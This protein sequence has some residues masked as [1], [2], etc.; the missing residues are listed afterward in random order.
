[1]HRIQVGLVATFLVLLLSCT[2]ELGPGFE[3]S[4]GPD[5]GDTEPESETESDPPEGPEP[6]P[7]PEPEPGPEPKPEPE[8]TPSNSQVCYPG[9]DLA[10]TTCFDLVEIGAYTYPAGSG[11]YTRPNRFLDV[12]AVNLNTFLTPNF[13]LS[14]V[15]VRSKGKYQVAQ[16]HAIINLQNLRNMA[17]HALTVN[18]AFRSPVYNAS[19]GGA[20][21]SRHMYGD[22][23]DVMPGATGRDALMQMCRDLGAGYVAKYA[24]SGHIHCDWRSDPLDSDF[25]GSAAMLVGHDTWTVDDLQAEI[26]NDNG[27]YRA[28]ATGYDESEG[29]FARDWI[30]YDSAGNVLAEVEAMT[31][32][33]PEGTH[34]VELVVGGMKRFEAPVFERSDLNAQ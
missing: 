28:I 33:A 15:C 26:L 20:T 11:N 3:D 2:A 29:E 12:D 31:F 22:A 14:E 10:N 19:I 27:V 30:A 17:G 21:K 4:F 34:R 6:G 23:F 1:M 8:P 13:K 9:S 5:A 25:F 7:E 18:S 24:N 32:V 16:P